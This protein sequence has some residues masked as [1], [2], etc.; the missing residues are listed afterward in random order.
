M[1]WVGFQDYWQIILP[2]CLAFVAGL[3]PFMLAR[4]RD[5]AIVDYQVMEPVASLPGGVL[6]AIGSKLTNRATQVYV[7]QV[8]LRNAGRKSVQDFEV[9]IDFSNGDEDFK[10]LGRA[11]KCEPAN[12]FA[13]VRATEMRNDQ[14]KLN[15]ELLKP[16]EQDL[17]TLYTSQPVSP[18]LDARQPGI[19][20]AKDRTDYRR[21]F[22]QTEYIAIVTLAWFMAAVLI[23]NMVT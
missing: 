21:S 22:E 8:M 4:I 2:L 1:N 3:V 14:V 5:R 18:S 10:V 6:R 16:G 15:Y 12:P 11:H 13:N 23:F 20:M 19:L 7:T 9:S 17:I